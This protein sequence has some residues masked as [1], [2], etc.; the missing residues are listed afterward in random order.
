MTINGT[1]D[2]LVWLAGLL[3]GR[4]PADTTLAQLI[5]DYDVDYG[6]AP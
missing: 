1:H 6:V 2:D 4:D 3:E 5:S